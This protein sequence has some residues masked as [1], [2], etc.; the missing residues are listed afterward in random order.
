MKLGSKNSGFTLIEMMLVLAIVVLLVSMIV[1]IAKRVDDQGKER[2][3][4]NTIAL[5]GNALEQFRDFGYVY[6][7][8]DFAGLTFP[9]DCNGLGINDIGPRLSVQSMLHDAMYPSG[10]VGVGPASGY[11]PVYSGSATLYFIL[12]QVPDCRT[13]LD[14]IDK[15]LLT[16]AG[17]DGTALNIIIN[18]GTTVNT[19]P[20]TRIIDPWGKP[21]RYDYYPDFKDYMAEHPSGSW[22]GY[23][24]RM[25][26]GKKTFP[27]ITSAGPDKTFD[28]S[29]DIS[30]VQK[31]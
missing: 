24:D 27:V 26:S 6:K 17:T 2:L 21:L 18:S 5:I 3:C 14:K 25:A 1:G 30:N 4:R 12:S 20:F 19:Y 9:L 8:T 13:T 15:S 28:T 10:I 7:H 16:N 22:N 31:K 23:D 29:D 11:D